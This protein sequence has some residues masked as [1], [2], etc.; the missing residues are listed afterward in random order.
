MGRLWDKLEMGEA[1]GKKINLKN[2]RWKK[3]KNKEIVV[4]TAANTS[5]AKK[6]KLVT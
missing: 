1:P 2:R 3:V 4:A 5:H 6:T